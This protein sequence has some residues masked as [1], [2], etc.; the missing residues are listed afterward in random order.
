MGSSSDVRFMR[1]PNDDLRGGYFQEKD[2]VVG[3]T[4]LCVSLE[5]IDLI[6]KSWCV[7]LDKQ[8]FVLSL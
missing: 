2:S 6:C 1:L 8:S 5:T 4:A 7:F 3:N